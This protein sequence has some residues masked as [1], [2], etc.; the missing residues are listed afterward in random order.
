MTTPTRWYPDPAYLDDVH[1]GDPT[2][3]RELA[4]LTVRKITVSATNNCVY[5]LTC[6]QTGEQL[7]IDAADDVDRLADLVAEGSGR[8]DLVVT[9]HQHWDHTRALAA[10]LQR[11]P[12]SSAAGADDAD[13][14]PVRPTVRLRHGDVVTVGRARLEVIALRGHTPGSVALAYAEPGSRVHL[15]TGD[16]LFPGGV[17]NTTMP[18]QSFSSLYT[19]V[20][21]RVFDRFGD[22]TWVYPGHGRDTALGVERPFL[23]EWRDRGW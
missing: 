17:G 3:V 22:D 19:D 14:L 8:L 12:A 2:S 7:L 11:Y 5:L 20:V 15:F 21:E 4:G 1:P 18:G 10:L 16:S 9:T 23:H 6:T 13:A